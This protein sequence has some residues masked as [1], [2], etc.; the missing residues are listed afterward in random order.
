MYA[1]ARSLGWNIPKCPSQRMSACIGPSRRSR[2]SA[3]VG[4][5]PSLPTSAATTASADFSLRPLLRRP[6]GRKARSPQVRVRGFPRAT[7]GSTPSDL[8]SRE[9]RGHWPAR[10]GRPR[11]I[12]G[13][14]S[15]ARD[16]APRFF[17]RFPRGRHLAVRS[18]S[19]RPGS[20]EDFHLLVTPMLGTPNRKGGPGGPPFP[21]SLTQA[22]GGPGDGLDYWPWTTLM[23][24]APPGLWQTRQVSTW[25]NA[26]PA[27]GMLLRGA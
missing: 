21:S 11:L 5:S 22:A 9:L 19:L 10:P 23:S 20:P 8:W 12:S 27:T 14:C 3:P 18:G 15:S 16:F 25:A 13:S 1:S 6:F 7:A 2:G 17:Q 4:C 24:A 26:A